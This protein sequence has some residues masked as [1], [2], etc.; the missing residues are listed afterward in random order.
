MFNP[1]KTDDFPAMYILMHVY[2]YDIQAV[3]IFILEY[4]KNSI[5]YLIDANT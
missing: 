4:N 1:D 5:L 2:W 3:P